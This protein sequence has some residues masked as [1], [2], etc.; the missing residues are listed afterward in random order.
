MDNRDIIRQG[1]EAFS[2]GD[3]PGVMNIMADDISFNIPGHPQIP[4]ARIW[5]GKSGL[6]EFFQTLSQEVEFTDFNPREYI[7]EGDRVIVI[8]DY[9]GRIKRTNNSFRSDWV[10]AWRVKN[11]KA[12]ELQ[13][14]NDTLALAE[15][16]GLVS[17]AAGA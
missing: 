2:R 12:V 6:Q 16:F 17:R 13:E 14:Y 15:S 4:M 3:I 8:G 9:A 5:R 7:A 11:G 1:Y 10:M